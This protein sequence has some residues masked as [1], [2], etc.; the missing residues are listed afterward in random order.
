MSIFYI[1]VTNPQLVALKVEVNDK[2]EQNK[3]LAHEKWVLGQEKAQ[4]YGQIKQIESYG[5]KTI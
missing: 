1:M 3:V 5:I 4:L 2:A